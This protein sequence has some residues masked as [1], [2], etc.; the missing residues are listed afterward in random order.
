MCEINCNLR[1]RVVSY[2]MLDEVN[3]LQPE[4]GAYEG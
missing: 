2:F 3:H 4:R 1:L